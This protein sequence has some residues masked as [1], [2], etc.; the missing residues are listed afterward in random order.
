MSP[1]DYG[2]LRW[3]CRRGIKELDVLLTGWLEQCYDQESSGNQRLFQQFL[4]LPDPLLAAYLLG[5]E[6]PAD[7]AQQALVQQIR[8]CRR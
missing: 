2:R 6:Q 8:R 5:R 1:T 7:P 3:Q 4:E